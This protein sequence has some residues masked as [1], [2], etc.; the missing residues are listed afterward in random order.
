MVHV[1]RNSAGWMLRLAAASIL[2]F[3]LS[4]C[5]SSLPPVSAGQAA[6]LRSVLADRAW[7]SVGV[8][9]PEALRPAVVV[10]RTVP[11]HDWP[12]AMVECLHGVGITAR[13]VGESV[14][15]SSGGTTSLEFAVYYYTC[16]AALPSQSAVT[17][18][19]DARQEKA[20]IGYF[21]NVVKPCLVLLGR[22]SPGVPSVS[23]LKSATDYAAF[24]PYNEVY[25]SGISAKSLHVV[26]LQCPPVPSWLNLNRSE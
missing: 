24:N 26:E 19:L 12:A 22:V 17:A 20:L 9:Y 10:Q 25:E 3:V 18:F 13:Q 11:D 23:Y 6:Y 15:Y 8:S 5:S 21:Q 1:R 16:Q 14:I 7:V 4:A 2:C